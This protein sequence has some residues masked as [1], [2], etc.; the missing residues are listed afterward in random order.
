MVAM[1]VGLADK[2]RV[3]ANGP[4]TWSARSRAPDETV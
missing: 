1:A 3:S 2:S 4:Y